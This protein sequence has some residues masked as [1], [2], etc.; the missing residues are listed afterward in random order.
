MKK[1]LSILLVLTMLAGFSALHAFAEETEA[2]DQAGFDAAVLEVDAAYE[3]FLA[4]VEGYTHNQSEARLAAM[5]EDF[6]KFSGIAAK[7][8]DYQTAYDEGEYE[9][10]LKLY[11]KYVLRQAE[12]YQGAAM[13]LIPKEIC[14]A[15]GTNRFFQFCKISIA[16]VVRYGFFGWIWL[17]Y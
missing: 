1:L 15:L 8:F 14:E 2:L 6:V 17:G 10:A 12:F 11:T 5:N 7:L 3:A 4:Q 9:E 16:A 13:M